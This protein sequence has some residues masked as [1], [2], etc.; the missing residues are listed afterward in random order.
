[1]ID[2]VVAAHTAPMEGEHVSV[3]A[4]DNGD[5]IH[6]VLHGI[7]V[8]CSFL[9]DGISTVGGGSSVGHRLL[10]GLAL[11]SGKV[12]KRI[13]VISRSSSVLTSFAQK[14]PSSGQTTDEQCRN[15]RINRM[16]RPPVDFA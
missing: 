14:P 6:G 12:S 11:R 1:M 16:P 2:E 9:L 10:L 7:G 8:G 15:L 13:D 4:A 5:E 3:K